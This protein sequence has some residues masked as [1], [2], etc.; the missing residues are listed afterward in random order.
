MIHTAL[1][2]VP[3]AFLAALLRGFTGFGF[4]MAAVPLL[5]LA[6]PPTAV[7]PLALLL[8]I[9]VGLLDLPGAVGLCDWRSLAWLAP[10]MLLGTPLG[11]LVLL[12]LSEDRA[13][14]AIGLLIAGSVAVLARGVHLP[15]RPSRWLAIGV[16]VVSGTMNGMAGM[17]GP[18][19]VAYLLALPH[20]TAVVRASAI[21]FFVL[22]ASSALLLMAGEGL[23]DWRLLVVAA[24]AL[25]A[26]FAGARLGAWGFRRTRPRQHRATA[27]AVLSLLAASLILRG[28]ALG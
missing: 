6:L 13:R 17:A 26:L 10:G 2:A 14:L 21:V 12:G 23:I 20:S 24:I 18:P 19:V 8:Q 4:V 11:V 27:L 9:E 25:P 22:T 15:E 3:G 16:G 5:S 1:F 28:L 7:V